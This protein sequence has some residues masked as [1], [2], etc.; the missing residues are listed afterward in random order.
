[1]QAEDVTKPAAPS[2]PALPSRGEV[3]RRIGTA[4]HDQVAAL[5]I[6]PLFWVTLFGVVS[7]LMI[8]RTM[9]LEPPKPPALSLPLPAFSLTSE[10]GQ[11]FGTDQLRGKVWVAD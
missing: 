5:V 8:G 9:A 10:H 2:Q 1:M 4:L 11:P 7:V 6:R 3:W